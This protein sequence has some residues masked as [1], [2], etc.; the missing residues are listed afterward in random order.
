[1]KLY[2]LH[3]RKAKSFSSFHVE[4]SDAAAS[5]SFADAVMRP[6]SPLGKYAEDF[7]L[8]SLCDVHDAYG[9]SFVGFEAVGNLH[10]VVVVTASQVVSLQS[11]AG[12]GQLSLLKEA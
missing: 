2:A 1:M 11:R 5:R 10:C 9:D 4:R 8:V 7:E 6:D 12:D 3:D